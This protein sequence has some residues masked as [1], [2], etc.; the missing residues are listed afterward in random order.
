MEN[1]NKKGSELH[2]DPFYLFEIDKK[3]LIIKGKITGV[4][5]G[6]VEDFKCEGRKLLVLTS[7][8]KSKFDVS[9]L[10]GSECL[11]ELYPEHYL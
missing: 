10:E 9:S 2:S 8:G 4:E 5:Y 3:T 1:I 6:V 7:Q 11:K